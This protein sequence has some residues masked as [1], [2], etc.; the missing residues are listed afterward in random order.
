MNQNLRLI[1]V[2]GVGAVIGSVLNS[3]LA[4]ANAPAWMTNTTRVGLDQPLT[5]DLSV[6]WFSV[7]LHLNL[8]FGSV[9][10]MLL[11]VLGF[12]KLK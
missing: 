6:L 5:L 3:L 1:V 12:N 2:V 8:S 10:G 11:A 9:L 4:G 7:G